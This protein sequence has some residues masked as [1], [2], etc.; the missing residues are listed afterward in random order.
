MYLKCHRRFKDGEEHRYWSIAEKRRVS[1]RRT[2]DRH[3]L[4]LGVELMRARGAQY[5]VGTPKG[6]LNKLEA[7]LGARAWDAGDPARSTI[8]TS[9]ASRRTSS[10]PSW[11]TACRSRTSNSSNNA[12]LDSTPGNRETQR[13]A[14]PRRAFPDPPTG[15]NSSSPAT[16]SRSRTNNCYSR[17]WL[18]SPRAGQT[19]ISAKSVVAVQD[20]PFISAH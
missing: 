9:S 5:L 15:A 14:T 12:P 4:Y 1:A 13:H 7:A 11:P 19:G 20:R 10:A 17:N 18:G 6:R 3:V 2:V 16:L 8:K